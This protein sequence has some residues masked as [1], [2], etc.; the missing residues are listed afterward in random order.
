[1]GLKI[2]RVAILSVFIAGCATSEIAP[3]NLTSAKPPKEAVIARVNREPI[4]LGQFLAAYEASGGAKNSSEGEF[5]NE[6]IKRRI[7]V[8]KARRLHLDAHPVVFYAAEVAIF[9]RYLEDTYKVQGRWESFSAWKQAYLTYL[10]NRNDIWVY[11]LVTSEGVNGMKG[12]S[13]IARVNDEVVTASE[14]KAIFRSQRK[15]DNDLAILSNYLDIKLVNSV[16]KR[17]G[18]LDE[19]RPFIRVAQEDALF[20]MVNGIE[21]GTNDIDLKKIE[22]MYKSEMER[23]DIETYSSSLFF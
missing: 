9:N 14:F 2:Y 22:K 23:S 3:F 13:V 21:F 15:R 7:G 12:D 20:N 19:E 1:M 17:G 4:T 18:W 8:Q 10:R 11:P 5:L 16:A 6:Y